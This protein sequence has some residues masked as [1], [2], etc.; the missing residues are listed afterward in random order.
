MATKKKQAEETDPVEQTTAPTSHN[1]DYEE[2]K[3]KPIYEKQ[4]GEDG[5]MK[6]I[7]VGF[8]KDAQKAIRNVRTNPAH[9]ETMNVQSENTLLR[10]YEI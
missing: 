1:K 5:S 6:N 8:E 10:L 2:W 7:C 3:V 4:R 9:A